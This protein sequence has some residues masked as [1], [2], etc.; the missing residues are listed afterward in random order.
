MELRRAA[1]R[2]RRGTLRI[3]YL[4]VPTDRV[5]VAYALP[6]RVGTAVVRNRVRRRLRSAF[7]SIENAGQHSFPK[8]T[9]LVSASAEVA[10]MPFVE[11]VASL[12]SMLR[13]LSE[14]R[15]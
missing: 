4:P 12:T 14:R 9:Y 8:G 1:R 5:R 7:E 13:E 11:L 6:K 2:V 3:A 15:P 10:R